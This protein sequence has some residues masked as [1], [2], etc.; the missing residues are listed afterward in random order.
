MIWP[1]PP[2]VRPAPPEP[3]RSEPAEVVHRSVEHGHAVAVDPLEQQL[4][5]QRA[6]AVHG[7]LG[8]AVVGRALGE[9]DAARAWA[10][11]G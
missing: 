1:S 11:E 5:L 6:D 2:R 9:L 3:R 10:R 4:V 7:Q 8:R